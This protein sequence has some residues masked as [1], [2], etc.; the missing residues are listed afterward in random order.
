MSNF[1][2]RSIRPLLGMVLFA[3]ALFV[4][5]RQLQAHSLAEVTQQLQSIP[6]LTLLLSIVLAVASYICLTFYD[7]LALVYV[8][9]SLPYYKFGLTSFIAYVFSMDLGLTVLGS[10]AIRYRLYTLWGISAGDIAKIVAFSSFTF[11]VGVLG[12]GGP[13]LLFE[14]VPIPKALDL[15][16]ES[17]RSAGVILTA[18]FL[19]LM[20]MTVA[21]KKPLTI[22]NFS[23]SLPSPKLT[24]ATLLVA[25]ADWFIAS[26]VLWVLLPDVNG[27][28]YLTFVSIFLTCEVLGLVSTVPAGLGVFEGVAIALLSPYV[29]ASDALAALLAWRIIYFLLP[30]FVAICT[31]GV[32]EALQQRE[33]LTRVRE[34]ATKLG[35]A[36]VP[37][38]LAAGVMV[39]G[40]LLVIAGVAPAA[41]S[42]T[43]VLESLI[44]LF[45]HTLSHPISIISGVGLILLARGIQQR[46]D[47]TYFATLF[48]LA[49][50]ASTSILRGSH[51]LLATGLS[52]LFLSLIPCRSFF[53]RHG[54]LLPRS[55]PRELLGVLSVGLLGALWLATW[56][57][58]GA[59]YSHDLWL[60]AGWDSD[61][62]NSLRAL[63]LLAILG[64][65]F[66]LWRATRP[67]PPRPS[68]ASAEELNRVEPL[69]DASPDSSSYLALLGDKNLLFSSESDG[70]L[71]YGIAGKSWISMGDPV[72][73]DAAR[74][75]LAWSLR[76]LSDEFG[77][78]PVFYEIGARDIP[79]YLD[80][81]LTV[82][83]LGEK[84]RVPLEDFSLEGSSRKSMR[85]VLSRAQRDGCEFEVIPSEEVG[86][87]LGS[88]Q[89]ISDAWLQEKNT[90]EKG[91]S[92]GSFQP[93]YIARSPVALVR[94]EGEIV[95]FA[96]LWSSGQQE[97]VAPDLMR[98]DPQKAPNGAMDYLFIESMLWSQTEGYRW[99]SLGM[100]PLSG[101]TEHRLAPHW[102]R[103]G[104]LLFH[105]G[106]HF[107]NFQGL[108]RYKDKYGPVWEPRYLASPGGISFPVALKNVATLISG[109]TAG[110]VRR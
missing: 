76:E 84:G 64:T 88:L 61:V 38:I 21:R 80:L 50:G 62:S 20:G 56:T 48:I 39:S 79:L 12:V 40:I 78:W 52:L 91:F 28:D 14:A 10:S 101:M 33:S 103:L 4:L 102:N 71:M 72:G 105:H 100:A 35:P 109:G 67:R 82:H 25:G 106:E 34:L 98:F 47:T 75:E 3:V 68:T 54:R 94:Y 93:D 65:A 85:Q 31:L 46:V 107:Y 57:N 24:G 77:G 55:L 95:A 2:R 23:L 45:I 58:R 16:I 110:M 17:T 36:I 90:R 83:K 104:T 49:V 37:R 96:N 74:T 11:F 27:L 73:N 87:L 9:R 7:G 86:P 108:R 66:L 1:L 92:L 81:G 32:I 8:G 18:G 89:T 44:P 63:G 99:F 43:K 70:F 15:P 13:L 6:A 30:I 59:T 42:H 97:E 51:F 22:R 5:D 19:I 60:A 53:Y 29:P 26:G 69:V 41:S